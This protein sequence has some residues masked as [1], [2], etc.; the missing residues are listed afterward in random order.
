MNKRQTERLTR[1]QLVLE[2]ALNKIQVLEPNRQPNLLSV[3]VPEVDE[4][5]LP[6]QVSTWIA[7]V[8]SRAAL[9]AKMVG[10]AVDIMMSQPGR[11]GMIK[12]KATRGEP[13]P[14]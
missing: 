13:T 4:K 6:L 10:L 12:F 3:L 5:P 9:R 14:L 11:F 7:R 1:E 2:S 8:R